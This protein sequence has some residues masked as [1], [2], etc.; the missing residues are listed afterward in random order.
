M[1]K[2]LLIL[3]VGYVVLRMLATWWLNHEERLRRKYW[4][5]WLDSPDRH[6]M[7]D[8]WIDANFDEKQ[9][10]RERRE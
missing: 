10:E 2:V 3:I 5:R 6:R 7:R 1:L 8:E 4:R 9:R